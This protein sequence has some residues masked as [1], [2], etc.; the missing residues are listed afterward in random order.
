MLAPTDPTYTKKA[1]VSEHNAVVVAQIKKSAGSSVTACGLWLYDANGSLIKEHRETVTNVG[2][3]T[4]V[5]HSWY[6]INKEV[7]VTLD[8]GTTYQYCFFTVVNGITYF[9]ET[10]SFT[11]K[12]SAPVQTP[13]P[14]AAVYR[15]TLDPNGGTSGVTH[16]DIVFYTVI[17]DLVEPTRRGYTFGG[18]YTAAEGGNQIYES[19]VYDIDSDYTVY[20]HWKPNTYRMTLNPNGG[21]AAVT[22]KDFVFDTVLGDLAEPTRKGY[23]FDGW[24]TAAEGGNRIYETMRCNVDFNVTVYAH[25]APVKEAILSNPF[26]DIHEGSYYYDAVIWA[27]HNNVTSGTS[28]TTFSPDRLCSRGQV[29]TF[30]WNSQGQPEPVGKANPFVDV[31]EDDWYYKAVLWAVEQGISSG[32]SATTFSPHMTC[33]TGHVLTFLW[34]FN[35]R[36]EAVTADPAWY[37]RAV[38]WADEVGLLGNTGRGF[39]PVNPSP[40]SEIVTYLYRNAGSPSITVAD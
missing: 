25:W 28:A 22:Y 5:F 1:S 13:E 36:P 37:A 23:T 16:K 19:T 35:G 3:N 34:A 15:L 4:T 26:T 24:Y 29:V 9:G 18:W 7:G 11:T 40:R 33:T 30:L 17:G 14:E 21:A 20:A 38:A 39:S 6:D 12:G 31:D 32:T 2:K 27:K 10:Y 8:S